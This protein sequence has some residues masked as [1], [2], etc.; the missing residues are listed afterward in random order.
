VPTF[1]YSFTVRAPLADVAR[2]HH[3]TEALR[4]LTP[5]PVFVQLRQI[6]PLGEGSVSKFTMWFGPFPVRW[7][8]VHTDVDPE[9]GFTDTQTERGLLKKWV[10]THSFIPEDDGLTRVREHIEYEHQAGLR[11]LTSRLLFAPLMLR[12]LFTYRKWVTRRTLE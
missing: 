7:T 2:F 6:E 5:P 4:R 9:R 12:L 3:Q 10:H 8:A 1:D 11:G